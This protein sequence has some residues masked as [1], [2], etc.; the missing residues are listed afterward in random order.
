MNQTQVIISNNSVSV[1][2]VFYIVRNNYYVIYTD[3]KVDENNFVVL[4]IAKILQEVVTTENGPQPTGYLVG[5]TITND[6]EYSLVKQDIS[7]I[8][9]A[10]QNNIEANVQFF[11]PSVLGQIKIRDTKI[12]RLKKDVFEQIFGPININVEQTIT[13]QQPVNTSET[14][15]VQEV[16]TVNNND[17]N[18]S[19]EQKYYQEVEKNKELQNQLDN[20]I[21]QINSLKNTLM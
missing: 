19:F 2:A 17:D 16:P 18:L 1:M 20:L 12:F 4:Y 5:T 15:K 3:G 7:N 11:D 6:D 8:I 13:E 14:E 21:Q 10:K 9:D